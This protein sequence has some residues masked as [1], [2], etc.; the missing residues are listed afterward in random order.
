M[1]GLPS[2]HGLGS[3]TADRTFAQTSRI[4]MR[5]H[6]TTLHCL[7]GIRMIAHESMLKEI[8]MHPAMET[9][10]T[11]LFPRLSSKYWTTALPT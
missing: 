7:S 11:Q 5:T 4:L 9:G 10:T 2:S 6:E 8:A 1:A 3:A